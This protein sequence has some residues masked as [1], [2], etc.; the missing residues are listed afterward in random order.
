VIVQS[1]DALEIRMG[2]LWQE[3]LDRP[4]A[5]NLRQTLAAGNRRLYA[6]WLCQVAH[7][8]RHTSAHQALVATRINEVDSLY[9]KYCYRHAL[10]EVGHEEMALHDLRQMGFVASCVD[11]LPPPLPATRKLTALLYDLAQREHPA[12]RLGFSYWAEKCYP[13]LQLLVSG[14][15]SS[16]GLSKGQMTFFLSHA[17]IDEQ[18]GRDVERAIQHVCESPEAWA[19]VEYGMSATLGLAVEIFKEVYEESLRLGESPYAAFLGIGASE[20]A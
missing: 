5:A 13:F 7:Q 12:S 16:L 15:Q 1:L 14:V 2:Q 6:L 3:I 4:L 10:E 18:H 17:T 11:D 19:A 8:T 9:A 20:A